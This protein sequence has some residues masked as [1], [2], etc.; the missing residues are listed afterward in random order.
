MVSLIS[1]CLTVETAG[2]MLYYGKME[3]YFRSS[4]YHHKGYSISNDY[5]TTWR[6][7]DWA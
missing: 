5:T 2:M 6:M 7:S 4:D 3:N 1:S